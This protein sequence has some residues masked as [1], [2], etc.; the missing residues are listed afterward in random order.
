MVR[1]MLQV[2]MDGITDAKMLIEYANRAEEPEQKSWFNTHARNR[3]EQLSNDFTYVINKLELPRKVQ[4]G[5][6]IAEAL[7]GHL[8][9]EVDSLKNKLGSL[10]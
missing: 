5:D 4:E 8:L 9:Y 2:V 6:E 3:I 7:H 10:K 1:E